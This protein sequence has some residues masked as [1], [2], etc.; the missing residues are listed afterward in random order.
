MNRIATSLVSLSLSMFGVLGCGDDSSTGGAGGAGGQ[1]VGGAG[2]EAQ[3]ASGSVGGGGEAEGGAS[4]GGGG[5]GGAS[6]M[7]VVRAFDAGAFELPEGLVVDDEALV[8]FAFTGAV[9]AV[10]LSSGEQE[11]FAA[12]PPPP[13]DS[14]FVTGLARGG[15]GA[16]YLA[17]VSFDPER[18]PGIYRVQPGASEA[19]LWSSHPQLNFPNGFAFDDEG[20]LYVTDSAAGAIFRFDA[21]GTA[22]VWAT[23]PL[24][25]ADATACGQNASIAVG[26]NGLAFGDGALYV[27]SSDQGVLARLPILPDGSAGSVEALAGPSCDLGGI[28]GITLGRDGLVYAAINRANRVVRIDDSGVIETVAQGAPLDFPA[29]V[30]F[31]ADGALYVTSFGLGAFLSG[32][33]PHPAL[34][35][36]NL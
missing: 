5:E 14:A 29:S 30:A 6:A 26:A 28:D 27:A 3:G 17:Y 11:D 1:P 8:G 31:G 22:E 32:G 4:S 20:T 2:G 36:V 16:L 15:D 33:E 35:R 9:R 7:E 12:A 10:S 25:A 21:Q 23:D 24:L 18:T 34:V 19:T 13:S